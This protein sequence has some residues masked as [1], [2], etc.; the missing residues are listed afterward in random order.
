M[1]TKEIA[2]AAAVVL[3]LFTAYYFLSLMGPEVLMD[4]LSGHKD[5]YILGIGRG[6]S[7]MPAIEAGDI[8]IVDTQPEKISIGDV[9]VYRYGD[10]LVGHR[11]IGI[12]KEGYI[13]KGD[14]NLY[15]DYLVTKDRVVGKI[16]WVVED[17][18]PLDA[19]V[20]GRIF[21]ELT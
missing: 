20:L 8:V 5:H 7:M 11:V 4:V 1:D 16:V 3:A 10:L 21:G 17:P 18:S 15:T 6:I 12:V 13:T 19:W 2:V 9:I 14:N